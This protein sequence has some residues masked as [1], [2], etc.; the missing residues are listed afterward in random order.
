MMFRSIKKIT[1]KKSCKLSNKVI[2]SIILQ[3]NFNL[4]FFA[5]TYTPTH[6]NEN[7]SQL[8]SL[9]R[10]S[11]LHHTQASLNDKSSQLALL[12]D[13]IQQIKIHIRKTNP[14]TFALEILALIN[15][16]HNF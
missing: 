11:S 9:P 10:K 8:A 12:S 16:I 7:S 6:L 15:L 1:E 4:L 13:K 5:N 14:K 2:F 3:L